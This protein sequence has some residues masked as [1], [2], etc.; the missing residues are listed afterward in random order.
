MP[1][2]PPPPG[3]EPLTTERWDLRDKGSGL[4][5]AGGRRTSGVPTLLLGLSEPFVGLAHPGVPGVAFRRLPRPWLE[6]IRR[7]APHDDSAAH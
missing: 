4:P 6:P 1:Y 5:E 3:S 2:A 7:P